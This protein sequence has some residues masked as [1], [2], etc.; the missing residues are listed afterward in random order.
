MKPLDLS[1]G[2]PRSGHAR[3]GGV[4]F[5]PRTID[6][7]RALLPGGNPNGYKIPGIS[8]RMLVALG[9]DEARLREVVAAAG[10]EEE[11]GTWVLRQAGEE[12]MAAW[13]AVANEPI[14]DAV[15]RASL[16]ERYPFLRER[17]DIQTLVDLLDADEGRK[18][19]VS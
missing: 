16:E 9:I 12:R 11:I 8:E 4:A 10:G 14:R 19:P 6:K 1:K 3:V 15:H 13:N 18:A 7:M 2:P 17:V 5:L